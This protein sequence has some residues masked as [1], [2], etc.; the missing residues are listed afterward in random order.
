MS[1]WCIVKAAMNFPWRRILLVVLALA[2]VALVVHRGFRWEK[3]A[4]AQAQKAAAESH[5]EPGV[6]APEGGSVANSTQ[7]AGA[8]ARSEKR[9]P[10][11]ALR[12]VLAELDSTKRRAALDH[13]ARHSAQRDPRSAWT[14]LESVKGLAD[15]QI[16]AATVA[17]VWA[18]KSPQEA[19]QAASALPPGELKAEC[20]AA[21]IGVW[22]ES[23]PAEAMQ[24]VTMQLEGSAR[25]M[26]VSRAAS[27]WARRNPAAAA[28]WAQANAGSEVGLGA[29]SEVMEFWGDTDPETGFSWAS[30]LPDGPFKEQAVQSVLVSWADQFPEEAAAQV[31]RAGL[32]G[33]TAAIVA[34][35][36]AKSDPAAAVT[37]ASGLPAGP[38]QESAL[39]EAISAWSASAPLSALEWAERRAGQDNG[40]LVSGILG[41]WATM[42][43][44]S[45]YEWARTRPDAAAL[46]E[47]VLQSWSAQNPQAFMQ[48]AGAVPSVHRNDTMLGLMALAA[49]E[50]APQEALQY[51]TSMTNAAQRSEFIERVLGAWEQTDAAAAGAWRRQNAA[52]PDGR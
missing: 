32:S 1:Q 8:A 44:G 26:A 15:R 20:L 7:P 9:P 25:Q 42:D 43:V 47:P 13:F 33:D 27:A 40:D 23:A 11:E 6:L 48:W 22:A 10:D 30:A 21:A 51:A 14:M 41:T 35:V 2:L 31:S 38:E 28:N 18:G 34:S 45:A 39:R 3:Q 5:A 17:Q 16:Y 46:I 52:A 12:S 4:P 29:V 36:W 19:L 37:W 50:S 49:A 24:F